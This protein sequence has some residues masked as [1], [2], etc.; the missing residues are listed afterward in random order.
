MTFTEWFF[1]WP[2]L[3]FAILVVCAARIVVDQADK[4]HRKEER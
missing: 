2:V 3:V 4:R 1:T